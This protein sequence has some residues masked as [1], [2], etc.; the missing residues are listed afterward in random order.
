M[1]LPP[2]HSRCELPDEP[3]KYGNT[4]ILLSAPASPCQGQPCHGRDLRVLLVL[5]GACAGRPSAVRPRQAALDAG[6]LPSPWRANRRAR[7]PHLP[8]PRAP[9]GLL[10]S[11]PEAWR[12]HARRMRDLPPPTPGEMAPPTSGTSDFPTCRGLVRCLPAAIRIT[13]RSPWE[14]VPRGPGIL[15]LDGEEPA[16]DCCW[17][18]RCFDGNLTTASPQCCRARVIFDQDDEWFGYPELNC[19]PRRSK[20]DHPLS[21]A[22]LALLGR[23]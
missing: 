18:N 4:E 23:N 2:C 11:P 1:S 10:L 8:R 7:L 17:R 5:A 19:F 21:K 3:G 20:C 9:E 13:E 15:R 12:D 14:S 6:S 22:F 16:Q